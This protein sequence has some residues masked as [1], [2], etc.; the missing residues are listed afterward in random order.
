[1]GILWAKRGGIALLALFIILNLF[2]YASSRWNPDRIPGFGEWRVLSV[3]T[4]SMAPAIN[5][6]DMVIVTRYSNEVPQVGD[7]V[8]YWKDDQSRSLITHRVIQRLENG[9][10]QTKGDANQEADGGWTDPNHLVGKVVFTIPFAAALQQLMK[11]PLVMFLLLACFVTYLV[12]T[13]RRHTVRQQIK[14]DSIQT[15]TI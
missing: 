7:M 5:A 6:G 13:Q 3:L 9:Y 1:M 14:Q 12:Y 10:L 2:L 15:E 4:G 8:T 11:E